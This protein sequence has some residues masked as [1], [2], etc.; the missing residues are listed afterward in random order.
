MRKNWV[1]LSI[2]LLAGMALASCATMSKVGSE[3]KILH[4]KV[5]LERVEVASYFPYDPKVRVPLILGFIFQM[6]NPNSFQ[7]GL[8]AIKFTVGFQAAD[9]PGEFFNLATPMAY[10]V[11]HIPGKTTNQL[12]VVAVIDSLVVPGNLAVTSGSRLASLGLKTPDLV[13]YWYEKI[14][15]FPFAIRVSEGSANFS[16]GKGEVIVGFEGIFPKK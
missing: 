16:A 10:E 5:E 13:K 12:R 15:D 1:V 4:P 6:S 8:E 7:V 2:A 9:K 3:G 14:G 11:H